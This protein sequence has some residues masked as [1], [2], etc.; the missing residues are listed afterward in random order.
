MIKKQAYKIFPNK[1]EYTN[2]ESIYEAANVG[3][4]LVRKYNIPV[5]INCCGTKI[6]LTPG[7]TNLLNTENRIVKMYSCL[8]T[9]CKN[10]R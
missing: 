2:N 4:G 7:D 8:V 6:G 10:R 5:I 3:M 1:I 9:A